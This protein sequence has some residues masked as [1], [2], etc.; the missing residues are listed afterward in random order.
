MVQKLLLPQDDLQ[1]KEQR[2]QY[3]KKMRQIYEYQFNFC[4]SI[5]QLKKLRLREWNE[6]I[7]FLIILV[8]LVLFLPILIWTYLKKLIKGYP[9]SDY[10]D[11]FFF[12]IFPYPDK[13]FLND[14]NNDVYFGLQRVAGVNPIVIER[15]STKANPLPENFE[16]VK[17][18]VNK[19]LNQTYEEALKEGRLYITNYQM[20]KR[21]ADKLKELDGK[22]TQYVTDPVALYYRQDDGLL[23]PLAIQLR[24]SVPTSK[25]NP[26]YTP[27]DGQ[28]WLMAKAYLQTAD[29]VDMTMSS[30]ATRTHYL[31][32]SI[33]MAS[34]RNLAKNHPVF[35]LLYPQFR[36]TLFFDHFLHYFRPYKNGTV[37]PVAQI[38]PGQEEV[39]EEFVGKSMRTYHF[40]DMA[41]PNDI[42][43]RQM[44]DPNLFYPYRDDGQLVWDAIHQFVR[45]YINIYYKSDS[46]VVEDFELQGWADEIGGSLAEKKCQ[47]LGFPTKFKTIDQVIEAIGNIIFIATA[48]H[49]VVHYSQYQYLAYV[50]NMPLSLY[51]PPSEGFTLKKDLLKL[52]PT[53]KHTIIQSFAFYI[54][55]IKIERIGQYNLGMFDGRC[56]EIIK[57]YQEKLQAISKEVNARNQKRIFPY[58]F[59]D[60][61]NIANSII[62]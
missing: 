36:G 29:V 12:A 4:G 5:A 35:A 17:S 34:Y 39:L 20:L 42:K 62:V 24:V 28:Y 33:I 52:L 6:P 58:T 19:L 56:N 15:L 16:E 40:K 21:M 59:L 60:P 7:L 25:T 2:Q 46:D 3:F 61:K 57:K 41:F 31:I 45:E 27:A 9:F 14:F 8:K 47:I 32:E 49:S 38:L 30:H 53:F 22:P 50:P 23:K 26:I 37:P 48:Q 44:E 43:N 18:V 10:K 51:A 55:N 11:Y 13:Q 54:N 1:G